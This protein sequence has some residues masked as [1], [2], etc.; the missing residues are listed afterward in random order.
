MLVTRL[1]YSPLMLYGVSNFPVYR[2]CICVWLMYVCASM[3]GLC[4]NSKNVYVPMF[5]PMLY[6]VSHPFSSMP[7]IVHVQSFYNVNKSVTT[8]C[9]IFV[10]FPRFFWHCKPQNWR[11]QF[12]SKPVR[13]IDKTNRFTGIWLGL[14]QSD[15]N[16]SM[17]WIL[18]RFCRFLVKPTK[19]VQS[20]FQIYADF[21]IPVQG[22]TCPKKPT[23]PSALLASKKLLEITMRKKNTRRNYH[24]WTLP[25]SRRV[26][27]ATR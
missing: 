19:L 17:F 9:M 13:L 5:L 23:S 21:S 20:V 7:P 8:I 22:C 3:Y 18:Y 6:G 27:R 1:L 16:F 10:D 12:W 2:L 4:S 11:N 24:L 14:F 15:S 25:L 26:K